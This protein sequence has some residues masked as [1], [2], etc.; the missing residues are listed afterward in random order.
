MTNADVTYIYRSSGNTTIFPRIICNQ[1]PNL[2][3][4][5]VPSSNIQTIFNNPFANCSSLQWLRLWNN[6]LSEL[7]P[8]IFNS[9][10]ALTYLDLDNTRLTS[11]PDNI[12]IGLENLVTLELRNN[13]LVTI[14]ES[15]FRPLERLETLYLNNCGLNV[16]NRAW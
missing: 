5:S 12:F 1:F 7:P 11:L 10:S 4:I 2:V 13:P 9:N 15:V 3:R 16:F 6:P 8:N 14:S